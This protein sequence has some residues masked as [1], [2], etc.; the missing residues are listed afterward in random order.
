MRYLFYCD[1]VGSIWFCWPSLAS[2]GDGSGI[3]VSRLAED[4]ES[5][6]LDGTGCARACDTPGFGG[7]GRV[8]WRHGLDRRAPYPACFP[9]DYDEHGRG[10]RHG[11]LAARRSVRGSRGGPSY[12]LAAVYLACAVLFLLLGPGRFSLDA[13]L[14]GRPAGDKAARGRMMLEPVPMSAKGTLTTFPTSILPPAP[15]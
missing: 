10:T 13:L 5:V 8:W 1:T 6:G 12:E 3:P 9:G 11:S 2:F 14:F 7:G 15:P 4:P